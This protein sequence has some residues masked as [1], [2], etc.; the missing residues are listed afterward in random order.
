V[1][2]RVRRV[3]LEVELSDAP[4]A[5]YDFISGLK[6]DLEALKQA[7]VIVDY[8]IKVGEEEIIRLDEEEEKSEQRNMLWSS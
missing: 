5:M 2:R 3:L 6:E 7:G 4:C 1:K 8:G